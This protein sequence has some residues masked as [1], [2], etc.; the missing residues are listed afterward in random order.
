MLPETQNAVLPQRARRRI[1]FVE[2]QM[3]AIVSNREVIGCPDIERALLGLLL[4]RCALLTEV[5]GLSP[6]H[7]LQ[8]SNAKIF[9]AM[10]LMQQEGFD[11][12]IMYDYFQRTGQL[13][14]IGGLAYL[15]SL[16]DAGF[17]EC[18]IRNYAKKIREDAER[19]DLAKKLEQLTDLAYGAPSTS[20]AE[21]LDLLGKIHSAHLKDGALAERNQ[22]LFRT[23]AQI[24]EQTPDH[25]VWIA[26]PWVA[27]GAITELAGKIKVS[28]KT[29]WVTHLVRAV[30]EGQPFLGHGTAKSPAVYLTEQ[31]P[32]TFR[33]AL[34]R[35]GLL[36]REDL[37]VL[38]WHESIGMTWPVIVAAA[39]RECERHGAQ[40]LVVDTLPQFTNLP[41]DDENRSG[42]ALAA[43]RPLQVAATRGIGVIVVRHE[44]KAGGDV[45]DA[46]RGNSAFGGAVDIVLSM[47]R[48][49][50]NNNLRT[51]QAI[52]RFSEMPAETIVE[53]AEDGYVLRDRSDRAAEQAEAA[54]WGLLAASLSPLT[55]DEIVD[56]TRLPRTNVQR[57][58]V[59]LVSSGQLVRI[60]EGKKGHPFRWSLPPAR[61]DSAQDP[62][63]YRAERN[64]ADETRFQDEVFG[65]WVSGR[66]V[67]GSQY[68]SNTRILFRDFREYLLHPCEEQDF[69]AALRGQGFLLG[70]DGIVVGL[71]LRADVVVPVT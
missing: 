60:G 25:V 26:P 21:I 8:S 68:S 38:F 46:A 66:C 43:M 62:S 59:E 4:C 37:H 17:V 32:R 34:E 10:Q 52:S 61:K 54:V 55:P 64:Q 57:A 12:A 18:N 23:A 69:T 49:E 22:G 16:L 13:K 35:A 47:R 11:L 24:A 36:G 9:C 71:A 31:S 39:V 19:R 15:D 44:R 70:D 45:G 53:L 56:A 51:I 20:T 5:D 63:L 65:A 42:D 27:A 29:T 6:E 2:L 41:G 3:A 33:V 30:L 28:G 48:T 67:Q 40:M 50:A 1:D 14:S 7:F 58:L